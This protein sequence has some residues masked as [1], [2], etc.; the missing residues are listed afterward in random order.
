MTHVH[1]FRRDF[2]LEDN[3][4]LYESW[5]S[6]ND[7]PEPEATPNKPNNPITQILPVFFFTPQQVTSKNSYKSHHAVQFMIRSL[8]SLDSAISKT[9]RGAS[10]LTLFGDEVDCLNALISTLGDDLVSVSWNKDYTPYSKKRDKRMSAFL[11]KHSIPHESFHDLYLIPPGEGMVHPA[12]KSPE[13]V[14]TVFTPFYKNARSLLKRHT[15]SPS[16]QPK[17]R[18]IAF[19]S[20]TPTIRTSQASQASQSSQKVSSITLKDACKQF[21][22]KDWTDLLNVEGGRENGEKRLQKIRRG[23]FA[24]FNSKRDQLTYETTYLS[25]YLKFGCI[26]PRETF[27]AMKASKGDSEPMIRELIW[28]DYYAHIMDRYPRVIGS[29]YYEKYKAF[30]W[31]TRTKEFNAWKQGRTGFP[32]VDAGMRQMNQTGYMHNRCRMIVSSFLVKLLRI[33]WRRGEKYFAQTLQDY[34]VASNNGG[35]QDAFGSGAGAQPYYRIF[36][37]WTQPQKYDKDA[38]YIKRWIPELKSVPAEKILKWDDP[39]VREQARKDYSLSTKD[40][41]EPILDYKTEREKTLKVFKA[42]L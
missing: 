18:G 39:D 42:T 14:Y 36:N 41:P 23:Q 9:T 40:Y 17:P 13:E 37:P 25:A 11:T 31:E 21:V 12:S 28:R 19:V 4:A 10:L 5:T 16:A 32:V 26:S 8:M 30:K 29:P 2:R 3:T 34:D 38:D 35:W 6:R 15:P 1:I 7:Q 27:H 20:K 22:G 33:D 24:K